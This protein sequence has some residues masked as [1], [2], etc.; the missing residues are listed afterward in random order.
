MDRQQRERAILG[1]LAQGN[2]PAFLRRLISVELKSKSATATIFVMPEYLAIGSDDDFLRIPMNLHTAIFI[3]D[4]FGFVLPTRKMVDAIY[5]HAHFRFTPQ[6][7]PAGP[8]M[9]STHYYQTHNTMINAQAGSRDFPSG[10]LVAGHK[11]DVVL[12]NRLTRM[13]GR[14][15]I[16]G[17]HRAPGM[18]IQPLS[19]VH[20]AAYADYSHGIR[21]V[22][23]KALVEGRLHSVVDMFENSTLAMALSYEGPIP[24][25][26]ILASS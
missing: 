15:A 7:L 6:P 16:Y 11:K 19:T 24:V 2:L 18:P 3:A 9:T 26:S 23:G 8:Q 20:G 13:A 22:A 4:R 25:A 1:Q 17:W 14:I 12:T 21:L 10:A 5:D